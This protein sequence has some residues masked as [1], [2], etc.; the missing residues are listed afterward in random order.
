MKKSLRG[1]AF[2]ALIALS[3]VVGAGTASAHDSENSRGT[4][5]TDL[6]PLP[7][8][9]PITLPDP[10]PVPIGVIWGILRGV[11]WE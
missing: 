8:P 10:L 1:L 6:G 11:T 2:A 4:A 7:F 5:W 3:M 9:L